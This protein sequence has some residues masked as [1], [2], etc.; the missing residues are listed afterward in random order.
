MAE[1]NGGQ[2]IVFTYVRKAQYY[3]TDQMGVVHHSNYAKWFE[4]A[5][6]A[7]LESAGMPYGDF[8][9]RGVYSPV[10]SLEIKFISPA[11]YEDSVTL[12]LV[13]DGY[14]GVKYSILYRAHC[15]GREILTARSTHVFVSDAFRPINIRKHAPDLHEVFATLV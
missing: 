15:G 10:T 6:G 7:W 8:E 3:E 14:N 5:R 2:Y 12:E 4:E 9:K 13:S 1:T 11:R